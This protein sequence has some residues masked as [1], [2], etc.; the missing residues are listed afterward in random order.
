[1]KIAVLDGT[2]Y[3]KDFTDAEYQVM[4]SWGALRYVRGKKWMQGAVTLETL[5][6]I[7]RLTPLPPRAAALR[8]QLSDTQKA[9]DR[10]RTEEKPEALVRFPVKGSLYEHQI[11]AA[12]MALVEF[13]LVD[14]EEVLK[15]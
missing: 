7:S 11:R 8:K 9:V 1:M 13:G 10:L 4:K 5:D 6:D 12:D 14:P 15:E 3:I 2:V